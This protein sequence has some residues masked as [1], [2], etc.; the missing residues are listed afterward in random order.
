MTVIETKNLWKK[1]KDTPA[2]QHVL[3]LMN[4]SGMLEVTE[5]DF[6]RMLW[7]DEQ[8]EILIKQL[9]CEWFEVD[10][11]KIKEA[12]SEMKKEEDPDFVKDARLDYLD[13]ELFTV[14]EY[15]E[16]C[17]MSYELNEKRGLDFTLRSILHSMWD[18]EEAEK[19][20]Q[21]L[22]RLIHQYETDDIDKNAITE[23]MIEAAREYPIDML[24]E[25]NSTGFAHCP[26][27]EEG[28]PSF[29]HWKKANLGHCFGCHKT[30][31]SI[32]LVRDTQKM[33][34]SEAIYFLTK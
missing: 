34:F 21:K 29:S 19:K 3:H 26:Y 10:R 18:I 11:P 30:V 14:N 22:L 32:Q 23:E 16:R 27:H 9:Y 25:F 24:I 8:E 33:S 7:W 1:S 13:N 15:L 31:D 5:K 6:D 17:H 2:Y 4:K 20:Q 12:I 28:T